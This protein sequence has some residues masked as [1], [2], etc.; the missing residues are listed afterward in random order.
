[1]LNLDLSDT[2]ARRD[3]AASCGS[4]RN[5]L[6]LEVAHEVSVGATESARAAKRVELAGVAEVSAAHGVGRRGRAAEEFAAVS[7][8]RGDYVLEDVA[9]GDDH[10]AGAVVE[11][12]ARVGIE[13]VVDSVDE[14]VSA[15]LGGA[16]RSVVDVVALQ[17]D[18]VAGTGEVESPVVVTIAGG[19]PGGDT[20]ELVVGDG[21]TV[22]STVAEN[23]HLATDEGELV[24]VCWDLLAIQLFSGWKEC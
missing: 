11:G 19:G 14:R 22:R 20:V 12:V 4:A 10:T 24:V 8:K 13:V 21:D 9:L 16:A 1:M 5:R 2:S 15:N 23:N 7:E 18:E 17:G 3:A 6:A